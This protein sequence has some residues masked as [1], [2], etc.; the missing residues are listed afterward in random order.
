TSLPVSSSLSES[1]SAPSRNLEP[2]PLPDRKSLLQVT[3]LQ[4]LGNRQAET[5]RRLAEL[6]SFLRSRFPQTSAPSSTPDPAQANPSAPEP[7]SEALVQSTVSDCHLPSP[8]RFDGDPQRVWG[9]LMQCNIQF[10]HSPHR[11]ALDSTK[12][13]YIIAHLSDCALDWAEVRFSSSTDFNCTYEE[14]LSEFKLAFNQDIDKSLSSQGLLKM[15]QG[16]RSVAD[17]SIDFRI[18]AAAS[19]WNSS[20]AIHPASAPPS[21]PLLR[22]QVAPRQTP[23]ISPKYPAITMI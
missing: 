15:R 2:E 5:N 13:S 1:A 12:I 3:A 18:Q 4:E 6:T 23:L 8:P 22:R 20:D 16:Q 14:F 9:F 11:F 17:F 7:A 21:S 10:N 19:G